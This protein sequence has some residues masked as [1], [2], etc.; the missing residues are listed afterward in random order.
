MSLH[1]ERS[2]ST[3]K[4]ALKIQAARKFTQTRD[5]FARHPQLI[6]QNSSFL[7]RHLELDSVA[8]PCRV[9]HLHFRVVPTR[10]NSSELT[11]CHS[12]TP[13]LGS[14]LSEITRTVASLKQIVRHVRHFLVRTFEIYSFTHHFTPI[15]LYSVV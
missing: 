2:Y 10:I 11:H 13:F 1:R 3:I 15:P 12:R 7:F 8:H 14:S 6:S 9:V 5:F 4:F